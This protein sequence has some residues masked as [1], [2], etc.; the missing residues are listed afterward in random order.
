[1]TITLEL[2][3]QQ[4]AARKAIALNSIENNYTKA[5]LSEVRVCDYFI[6]ATR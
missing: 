2:L 3:R 4:Y 5:L 1:M 6:N